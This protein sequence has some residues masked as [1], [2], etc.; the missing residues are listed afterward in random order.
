MQNNTHDPFDMLKDSLRI[1]VSATYRLNLFGF[2]TCQELASEDASCLPG[3]YGLWD[4]RLALEWTAANIGLFGGDS[5]NIS[6]GGLSAGAYSTIFQLHY[7]L[8]RPH[9]ADR[10]IKRIFLY[11]NAVGIQPNRV[12]SA[13]NEAQFEEL[14]AQVGVENSLTMTEKLQALRQVSDTKLA[15]AIQHLKHHTFRAGTDDDFISSKF[16]SGIHD[17]SFATLLHERNISIMLGEVAN[18]EMMYRLVNPATSYDDMIVQLNNYYPEPVTQAL[19]KIYPLPAFGAPTTAWRDVC[20]RIIADCQVHATVRGFTSCM[21]GVKVY[22]Y[23]ICWRAKGLDEWLDPAVKLCHAS[24]T[25]IWWQSGRRAGSTEEDVKMSMVF[26]KPFEQFLWGRE[27][28]WEDGLREFTAAGEVEMV[29]DEFWQRGM[30]IWETM[31]KAQ[32]G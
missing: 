5:D 1:I 9:P 11:S 2:M 29:E 12:D 4:Q 18:E 27:V 31:R 26:V 7:D 17:G 16:L 10:L 30:Q 15:S 28:E 21:K 22:R 20:A 25:P 8:R 32:L 24:D 23:R 3:N 13:D 19:V 14:A 6:V